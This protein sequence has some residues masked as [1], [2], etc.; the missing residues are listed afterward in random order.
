MNKFSITA[1][2]LMVLVL[3]NSTPVWADHRLESKNLVLTVDE[4]DGKINA[5][6]VR[7]AAD[8]NGPMVQV[9]DNADLVALSGSLAF[10]LT[11]QAILEDSNSEPV[12]ETHYELPGK[13]TVVRRI[14]FGSAPHRLLVSFEVDNHSPG[15][16]DLNTLGLATLAFGSGFNGIADPGA[17]YAATAYAYREAFISLNGSY[18]RLEGVLEDGQQ[19]IDSA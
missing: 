18:S 17:G 10:S 2:A 7:S 15:A 3:G 9:L 5:V 8:S 16:I 14:R 1:V 11:S 19:S 12:I 13:A 6:A 4:T